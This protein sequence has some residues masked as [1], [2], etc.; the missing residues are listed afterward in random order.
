[1]VKLNLSLNDVRNCKGIFN[2]TYKQ[3]LLFEKSEE[4]DKIKASKT[5]KSVIKALKT[6]AS[7]M[8]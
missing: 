4:T 3:K 6:Q 1:M 7:K 8:F 2:L 5:R